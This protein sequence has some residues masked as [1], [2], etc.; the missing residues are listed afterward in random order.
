MS[1]E[2]KPGQGIQIGVRLGSEGQEIDENQPF[3]ILV[4]SDFSGRANRRAFRAPN[5]LAS[6]RPK[7]VDLD[8]LDDLIAQMQVRL[9]D[10]IEDHRG[11]PVS[12]SFTELDDFHPDQLYESL[13]VFAELRDLRRRLLNDATFAEAAEE[14]RSWAGPAVDQPADDAGREPEAANKPPDNQSMSLEDVLGKTMDELKAAAEPAGAAS[15]FRQ[16]VSDLVAP[17]VSRATDAEQGELVACV[18]RVISRMMSTLLHHKD[19]QQLEAAWRG[20]DFLVRQLAPD[21]QL[22]IALVDVCLQ[23]IIA[24][25]LVHDQVENSALYRLLVERAVGTAGGQAWSLVVCDWIM[26]PEDG[27][28]EL[29]SAFAP[30][31]EAAGAALIAPAAGS[32]VGWPDSSRP[33]ELDQWQPAS[34][35]A[36]W[37]DLRSLAAADRVALVWPRF[38][39]RLPYGRD[40]DPTERFD[41]EEWQDNGSHHDYLWGNPAIA[42]AST[43]GLSFRK[44]GWSFELGEVHEL[45][46]LPLHIYQRDGET[47]VQPCAELLLSERAVEEVIQRHVVPLISYAQ[48]DRIQVGPI[49]AITGNWLRGPW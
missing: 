43:I 11:R 44:S 20:A 46:R 19:F 25:L 37:H 38:L 45:D 28:G 12:L 49:Q 30:I 1:R 4:L 26:E 24:D 5:D 48:Q 10:T 14:V 32:L 21:T 2:S 47:V 36:A 23:E 3:R 41:F 22:K 6:L 27:H 34:L 9:D 17:Y 39:L 29:L 42:V 16:I 7:N 31:V 40:T 15:E 8:N 35:P 13:P 18:D 33:V